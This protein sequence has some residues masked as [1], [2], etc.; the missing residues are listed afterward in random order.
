M[1]SWHDNGV[2]VGDL[3]RLDDGDY[4]HR[5][6]NCWAKGRLKHGD[7]LV[8]LRHSG[9][10]FFNYLLLEHSKGIGGPDRTPKLWLK[11]VT[12]EI[13][14]YTLGRPIGSL[15]RIEVDRLR[16]G[17]EIAIPLPE[18]YETPAQVKPAERQFTSF[19]E[20]IQALWTIPEGLLHKGVELCDDSGRI[21]IGG[22]V[23]IDT[24]S[25]S[26]TIMETS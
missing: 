5:I 3:F 6:G 13:G 2:A 21:S 17:I 16:W 26:V 12:M 10:C 11:P 9:D 1:R 18:L 4:D 15:S 25:G 22:H 19:G 20:L 7:I 24:V 8:A 23:L 14:A